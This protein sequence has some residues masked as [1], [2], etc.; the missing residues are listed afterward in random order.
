MKHYVVGEHQV[1]PSA[2]AGLTL[3]TSGICFERGGRVD[4]WAQLLVPEGGVI[5]L[6]ACKD[7]VKTLVAGGG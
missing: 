5:S 4:T 3:I 1:S 2:L 7:S 6:D